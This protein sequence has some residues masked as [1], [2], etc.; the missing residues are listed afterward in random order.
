M[1][2]TAESYGHAVVLHLKGELTEDALAGL[3]QAVEHHLEP[4]GVIDLVLDLEK[5]P[6]LDSAGLEYLLDL[7]DRLADRLGQVKL[8]K[9]DENVR[10]ILEITRLASVLETHTD[11]SAA[12]QATST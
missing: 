8:L 7:Q 11:P 1:D 2:L 6:F 12:V 10:T 4:K 3:R 5:V 9:P